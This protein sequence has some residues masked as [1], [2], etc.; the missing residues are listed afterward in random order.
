V[1]WHR[2]IDSLPSA[3]HGTLGIILAD[4][5]RVWRSAKP[6]KEAKERIEKVQ[7]E[8]QRVKAENEAFR[9]RVD[10]QNE[11]LQKLRA[12]VEVLA[13]RITIR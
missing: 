12:D 3:L 5:F 10:E 1:E 2:F 11:V 9:K 4:I 6:R 13:K 8:L 7:S